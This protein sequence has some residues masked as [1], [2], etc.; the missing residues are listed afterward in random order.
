MDPIS[1]AAIVTAF[2]TAAVTSAGQ[3]A[4]SQVVDLIF[5]KFE[6]S[7]KQETLQ[8][9]VQAQGKV[10][11]ADKEQLQTALATDIENDPPFGEQVI[12][13]VNTGLAQRPSLA[14][15]ITHV[16]G[17][18]WGLSPQQELAQKGRCPIGGEILIFPRYFNADGTEIRRGA[19]NTR[20]F[21]GLPRSTI[22]G[23]RRGHR[24][25][26]FAITSH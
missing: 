5:N 12:D 10:S 16:V 13:A 23:C 20:G 24:W 3:S 18:W 19:F 15:A 4:G 21:G 6:Q 1:I 25:P 2:L 14:D 26:V 17:N 11:E 7:G 9:V 22:A 8:P